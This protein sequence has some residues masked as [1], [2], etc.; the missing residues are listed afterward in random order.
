MLWIGRIKRRNW[1]PIGAAAGLVLSV[2]MTGP[3]TADDQAREADAIVK[4]M[5]DYL[6]SQKTIA[7]DFDTEI[8]VVTPLNQKLQFNSSGNVN[9]SRPS[10]FRVQRTGGYVDA[11]LID[12]GKTVT[13]FGKRINKY[14]QLDA[15]GSFDQVIDDLRNKYSVDLPAA[16]F[17]VSNPYHVLLEDVIESKHIGRGVIDGVE[18]EHLA[19][20]NSDADWQLWVRVGDKPIPCKYLITSKAV[21][22][23]P[24]Y[25]IRFKNWK[26]DVSFAPD[27]FTFKPPADAQKVNL[28]QLP[29]LDEV[30]DSAPVGGQK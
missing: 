19:F 17:F 18:C 25:S 21:G 16:D 4:A 22:E 30:P 6:A 5:S 28:G 23:A 15:S 13:L 7:F 9:I 3:S 14:A 29:N 20:R 27:A 24:Q 12:D 10:N 11:E 26:T 1:L 2:V 8:E